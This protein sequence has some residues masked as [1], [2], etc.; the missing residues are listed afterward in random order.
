M[1]KSVLVS[2]IVPFYKELDLIECA[3]QSVLAQS[4]IDKE[5]IEICLGDDSSFD[6]A[7]IRSHLSLGSNEIT[8]IVKNRSGKGAGNARNAAIEI[9]R[10]DVLA[11]LDADDYWLDGKLREQLALVE[12]GA[13]FVPGAYKFAERDAVVIPP[14]ALLSAR[15]AFLNTSIGT[16][17]IVITRELLGNSRFRNFEFSQDLDLWARLADKGE[18][19]YACT[20]NLV[21]I[22]APSGR[23]RNKLVQ[24]LSFRKLVHRFGFHMFDRTYIYAKY[25]LRGVFNHYLKGRLA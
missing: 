6:E 19:R 13:S 4:G 12:S 21:T 1:S 18:F 8:R 23:T 9:A 5:L 3:I 11:F 2:V 15:D 25:T 20:Q 16:S 24:F 10:G 17:T 7:T 14:P 22:Y